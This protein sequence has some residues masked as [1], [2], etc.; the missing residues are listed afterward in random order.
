MVKLDS[1]IF[2]AVARLLVVF[3]AAFAIYLFF[4]GHNYPGGGFIAGL[5]VAIAVALY[6]FA[7]GPAGVSRLGLA[8][9][10]WLAGGGLVAVLVS[11]VGPMFFGQMPLQHFHAYADLPLLGKT[12]LGLPVLFDLGVMLIVIGT[13]WRMLGLLGPGGDQPTSAKTGSVPATDAA[14]AVGEALPPILP[15]KVAPSAERSTP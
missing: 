12:Y 2:R 1:F 3:L 10:L 5:L 14:P 13:V 8:E 4:R 15:A 9:P 7:T 11:L 6:G